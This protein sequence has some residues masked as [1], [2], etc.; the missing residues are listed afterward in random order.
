MTTNIAVYDPFIAQLV[1]LRQFNQSITFDYEDPKGNKEARSH[2]YKL[3]QTKSAVENARKAE[4]QASLEYG[5][6][7]DAEAKEIIGEIEEMIEVHATPI[8]EIEER[9]K[10]RV[11]ALAE[12]VD[13]FAEMVPDEQ[14]DSTDLAERLAL[15]KSTPV[16]E[17]FE[18]ME[19]LAARTKLD[20]IEKLEALHS[21]A[22]KREADAAELER[23]RR[24]QAEREEREREDRIRRE[25]AEQAQRQAEARAQA[26]AKAAAA[27]A[28]RERQEQEHRELQLKLE[29][30]Q[31]ERR[32][33]EADRRAKEELAA[34]QRAENEARRK[35]EENQRHR[36]KINN[37]AIKA[38]VKGG[39]S[40]E[41]A[42]AVVTLIAAGDVPRVTI[43]Y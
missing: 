35:R 28:E 1:Q 22:A 29:K 7:V 16:D 3:R 11:A 17:S 18:E 41:Q 21:S 42:Q 33:D 37:Q 26:E 40:N 39:V 20:T 43:N 32:A 8:R 5:R 23:L 19:V 34:K 27:K 38:L 24:E 9:E 25:A 12:R 30:E 10:Q 2:I 14:A 15:V 31:A 4:K 6:R 13:W 36:T